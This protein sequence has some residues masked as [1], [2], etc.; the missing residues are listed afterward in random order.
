[1]LEGSSRLFD[2]PGWIRPLLPHSSSHRWLNYC[3]SLL[4]FNSFFGPSRVICVVRLIPKTPSLFVIFQHSLF[5]YETLSSISRSDCQHRYPPPPIFYPPNPF[6]TTRFKVPPSS[7]AP[8]THHGRPPHPS[9]TS[10]P[11]HQSRSRSLQTPL[12]YQQQQ[13]FS[14]NTT[15][16]FSSLPSARST[17]RSPTQNLAAE[18]LLA[19]RPGIQH[20]GDDNTTG[21]QEYRF[22]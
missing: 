5:S 9:Q 12:P 14:P 6:L 21:T 18:G 11:I 7:T 10:S 2:T 16:S 15:T 17:P 20:C 13:T 19:S 22:P 8:Q 4:L 1:M 3:R